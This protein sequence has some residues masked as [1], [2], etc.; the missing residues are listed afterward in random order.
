MGLF[1]NKVVVVTGGA[2]GIGKDTA[3]AFA[4]EGARV[5]IVD[6]NQQGVKTTTMDI[7]TSGGD[8][9]CVVGDVS[10]SETCQL[11]IER[12]EDAYGGVDILFNN[13]GIQ[14]LDSYTDVVD[15]SEEMWDRIMAVNL[16]SY[17]LMAKYAIPHMRR[18]GGGVIVN[19][20][21]V[22]G[23]QSM[24]KVPAYAASKGAV[25]A[26]TRAMALDHAP[27]NIRVVAICPGT[28]DTEMVRTAARATGDDIEETLASWG[29]MHPLGRIGTGRD[30]AE[31]VLF[32]AS[33]R[34]SFITGSYFCVD[35]GFM[36]QGAWAR[37]PG[38]VK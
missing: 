36:A 29:R 10:L 18:R 37:G 30:I 38:A 5:V 22:Q 15:T 3:I 14:P 16:K 32:L 1:D 34:A 6:V 11:V 8:A 28:I 26:L 33:E 17:F 7:R 27:E 23:L 25:L 2:A 9:F 13:V 24:P 20:A 4:C 35:G 12:T 19:N 31:A 21:S